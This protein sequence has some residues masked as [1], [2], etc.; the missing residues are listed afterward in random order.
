MAFP[1]SRITLRKALEGAQQASVNLQRYATNVKNDMAAGNISGNQLSDN[2]LQN[3]KSAIEL[4]ETAAAL[5]GMGQYAKDQLDMP[6]LDVGPEFTTMLNAAKA[7]RDWIVVNFPKDASG[8]MSYRTLNAD[9]SMSV[10]AFT[11]AQTAGL[12][13]ELDNFIATVG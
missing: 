7:V 10:D 6:G 8:K 4:W 5:P 1:G 9:G 12:R 2:L 3:F 13:T 11:P